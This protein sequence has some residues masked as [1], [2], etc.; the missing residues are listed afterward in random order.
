MSVPRLKICRQKYPSHTKKGGTTNADDI[1]VPAPGQRILDSL[2]GRTH[3][4]PANQAPSWQHNLVR[5]LSQSGRCPAMHNPRFG[6]VRFSL[7]RS[8]ISQNPPFS[9]HIHHEHLFF[10]FRNLQIIWHGLDIPMYQWQLARY[11]GISGDHGTRVCLPD[12]MSRWPNKTPSWYYHSIRI[13]SS[14]STSS[15][16]PNL[17]QVHV[18]SII[19]CFRDLL[20]W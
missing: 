17:W 10:Y 4:Q 14:S 19:H 1:D 9:S 7:G 5:I 15:L 18:G 6:H 2:E 3:F 11:R 16:S 20:L 12:N 13:F 8:Q